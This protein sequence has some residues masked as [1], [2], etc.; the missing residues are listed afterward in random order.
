MLEVQIHV[1]L[2]KSVL[3]PQGDTVRSGLATLGYQGVADCRIGKFMVLRLAER[4]P[5]KARAQVN[6]MCRR[7]L[8]NPVIEDYV[9]QIREVAE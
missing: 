2:K 3:D 9:F 5:A 1:T 4:D 8:A 7:L 6:E